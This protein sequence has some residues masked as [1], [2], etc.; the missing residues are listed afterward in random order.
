MLIGFSSKFLTDLNVIARVVKTRLTPP[1][2]AAEFHVINAVDDRQRFGVEH[3]NLHHPRSFDTDGEND[4]EE[5]DVVPSGDNVFWIQKHFY[6]G[7]IGSVNSF[8]KP[9]LRVKNRCSR[10]PQ[11]LWR[12][13]SSN[14]RDEHATLA[15]AS[16][17]MKVTVFCV[18]THALSRVTLIV[19]QPPIRVCNRCVEVHINHRDLLSFRVS[20]ISLMLGSTSLAASQPAASCRSE[21]N[22]GYAHDG[23]VHPN[24]VSKHPVPN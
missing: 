3:L 8:C 22:E 14:A 17:S 2:D 24:R 9:A 13:W 6:S 15:C 23:F 19:F 7:L 5:T 4:R 10:P 20:T 11:T 16:T 18:S 21:Y 12:S 1:S